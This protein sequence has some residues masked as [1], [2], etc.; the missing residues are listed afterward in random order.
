[1]PMS[2]RAVWNPRDVLVAGDHAWVYQPAGRPEK[3]LA[4]RGSEEAARG[5]GRGYDSV[6]RSR[7]EGIMTAERDRY[8]DNESLNAYWRGA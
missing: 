4:R 6:D 3:C 8:N 7:D 1:M 5:I 2:E